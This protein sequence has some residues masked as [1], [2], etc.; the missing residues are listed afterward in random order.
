M[1]P[2]GDG[3]ADADG[4]DGAHILA[5]DADGDEGS[6]GWCSAVHHCALLTVLSPRRHTHRFTTPMRPMRSHGQAAQP[7]RFG[8]SAQRQPPRSRRR[9]PVRARRRWL[10]CERAREAAPACLGPGHRFPHVLITQPHK[11]P[12]RVPSRRHD[13]G[14]IGRCRASLD[15]LYPLRPQPVHDLRLPAQRTIPPLHGSGR[16]ICL[17]P[18]VRRRPCWVW[19][20]ARASEMTAKR[21]SSDPGGSPLSRVGTRCEPR[22]AVAGP[23]LRVNA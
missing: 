23:C 11:R 15:H 17:W 3:L 14:T 10:G 20:A 2:A 18:D 16:G 19:P 9:R 7:R 6:G 8:V 21:A 1:A 5:A 13:A 4:A 12:R 22:P